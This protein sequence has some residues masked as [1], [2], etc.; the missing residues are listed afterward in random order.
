MG[1]SCRPTASEIN[2]DIVEKR[3]F[4]LSACIHAPVKGLETEFCNAI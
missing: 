4:F 3:K 1:V 2:D